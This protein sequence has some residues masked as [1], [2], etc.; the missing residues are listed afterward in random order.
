[1][2][3][4]SVIFL[5]LTPLFTCATYAGAPVGTP[6]LPSVQH[7]S[8]KK[9]LQPR[10][11]RETQSPKTP[12][13]GYV[14]LAT[15]L[16]TSAAA[17]TAVTMGVN[18][19]AEFIPTF[20]SYIMGQVTVVTASLYSAQLEPLS[21]WL[22]KIAYKLNEKQQ[23]A[24][25][26]GDLEELAQ[27]VNALYT[28]RDQHATDRIMTFRLALKQNLEAAASAMESGD[29]D[30]VSAQIVDILR[31]GYRLFRE[32]DPSDPTI[33]SAVQTTFLR[34]VAD[35]AALYHP[36]LSLL[37]KNEADFHAPSAQPHDLSPQMY[38]EKA[39]QAWLLSSTPQ[40]PL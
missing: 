22:R 17:T 33:I 28:L 5:L 37:K 10:E 16:A 39:L 36:I 24:E 21:N 13:R 8:C 40:E 32:I 12:L 26:S 18:P 9:I 25:R 29:S 2:F 14:F 20:V 27:R 23:K 34:K 31:I 6:E 3:R 7:A 38:Y 15:I 4:S 19:K 30:G 35:P 11:T 1:M